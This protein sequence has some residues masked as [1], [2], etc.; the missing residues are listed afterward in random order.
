M[1]FKMKYP[2]RKDLLP[3][4]TKRRPGIKL[5]GVKFLVLHDVGNDGADGNKNGKK[6]GTTAKANV[7]YY[8]NSAN[9]I[10]ASA[11]VFVDWEEIVEC[12]PALTSTPET[13]YHVMYNTPVD[14]KLFGYD[15]ND[16]AI[17]FELCYS[18]ESKEKSLEAYKRYI[19]VVAYAC[20][21][22]GLN[23]AKAITGH[24]ILDPGRKI[25]PSNGLKYCGKTLKQCIADIVDEYN[26]CLGKTKPSKPKP[27]KPVAD[28]TKDFL[29][30]VKVSSLNY[31]SGPSVDYKV[32]GTIKKNEIYTITQVK[33]GW[34]KL[35]SGAGWINISNTY[36]TK[37]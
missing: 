14:N 9:D 6:D 10:Y 21:R 32:N 11:Q 5:K 29:V 3:N 7:N 19:W 35:K 8:R 30:K 26:E 15:A 13:A 16:Y 17:G 4:K 22:Y 18:P 27:S 33:N 12:I 20:Y 36:V 34:G 25:D 23:P 24:E 2:I 28:N 1:A 37:L 31:R